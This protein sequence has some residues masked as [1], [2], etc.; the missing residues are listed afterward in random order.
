MAPR[1]RTPAPGKGKRGTKRPAPKAKVTPKPKRTSSSETLGK[2]ASEK[3]KALSLKAE[4]K[5]F[6]KASKAAKKGAGTRKRNLALSLK[7]EAERFAKASKAAKKGARTRKRNRREAEAYERAEREALREGHVDELDVDALGL[8]RETLGFTPAPEL[9]RG[10][11]VLEKALIK[12]AKT[13]T[14][15][16]YAVYRELK[17]GLFINRLA[18]FGGLSIADARALAYET[19]EKIANQLPLSEVESRAHDEMS[20]LA[21]IAS[22]NA[23]WDEFYALK[24]SK[25]S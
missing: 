20:R 17:R 9:A 24:F 19:I 16:D 7:A 14:T 13:G 10:W 3:L 6:A 23:G 2:A 22:A 11:N 8:T 18:H 12:Y 25:L 5:R 1:K 15:E 21:A 4:A